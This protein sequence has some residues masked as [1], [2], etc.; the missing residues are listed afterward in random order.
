MVP[1][2]T[3]KEDERYC[4]YLAPDYT[5]R[6][7]QKN[8]INQGAWNEYAGLWVSNTPG[9]YIQAS[10]K[11][12]GIRWKGFKYDDSG[13]VDI[14]I[15]DKYINTIDQ[16]SA[17]RDSPFS[18]E[19]LDLE[20]GVHTIKLLLTDKKSNYS[21]GYWMNY[22]QLLYY[23]SGESTA[24]EFTEAKGISYADNMLSFSDTYD[25][26][27]VS[28]YI[29]D[30]SGRM[31]YKKHEKIIAPKQVLLPD[32]SEPHL[33]VVYQKDGTLLFQAKILR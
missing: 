28:V 32:Y 21:K 31:L 27:H 15:D 19:K 33:V 3:I 4:I 23:S 16:Y 10:F 29:C 13:M 5:Y 6:I 7:E 18:W 8:I 1:Y 26:Q 9:D 2:Y 30:L 25:G 20:E 22:K 14:Y 17:Q 12:S 24:L 11:G